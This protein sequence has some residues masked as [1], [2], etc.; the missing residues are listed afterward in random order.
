MALTD[1]V[2]YLPEDLLVKVDRM[3][4]AF[5]LEARSPLLD[6]SVVNLAL[7]MPAVL[8]R[9]DDDGKKIV[10]QTFGPLFPPNFLD[11]P[12]MGFSLPVDGWLR[13]ELRSLVQR[14]VFGSPLPDTGILDS[15][16]VRALIRDHGRGES[17]G[18]VIW[19]LLVLGVW[20]DRYGGLAR[21]P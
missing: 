16:S 12:K 4:M 6:T 15:A 14:Y 17:H 18:T 5:G 21:L 1:I 2:T 3:S 10:K 13:T 7:S 9:T 20:F 19:N 11:R 8:K